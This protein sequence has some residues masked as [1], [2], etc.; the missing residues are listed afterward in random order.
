M[1]LKKFLHIAQFEYIRFAKKKNFIISL[2]SVPLFILFVFGLTLLIVSS[3]NR[4]SPIGYVDKAD[5]LKDPIPAPQRSGSP[6]DPS[7]SEMIPIIPYRSE[8]EA[9]KALDSKAIQAYYIIQEDYPETN[10]VELVYNK[11]PGGNARRQFWDFMQINSIR[12]IPREKALRVVSGSNLIIRWPRDS[13]GGFREFSEKNFFANLSPLFVTIAFFFLILMS[14]GY[15][16]NA[17]HEEKENRTMEIVITSIS[18]KEIIQGKV[19]SILLL[20][21]TQIIVWTAFIIFSVLAAKFMYGFKSVLDLLPA[22]GIVTKMILLAIPTYI[23]IASLM[24][25]VGSVATDP[26]EAHQMTMIFMLPM[27]SSFWLAGVIIKNPDGPLSLLLSFFPFSA[28]SSMS[29]RLTFYPVPYWQIAASAGILVLSCLGSIWLGARLFRFGMLRYGKK[30]N[31]KEIFS[32]KIS[33][34]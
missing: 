12:N 30:F 4:K 32:R 9:Q 24:V 33:H 17:F 10:N 14:A 27:M 11:R 20:S 8:D 6:N 31:L 23:M 34:E 13:P 28:F 25:G 22:A 21:M 29:F 7:T 18:G 15:T 3:E 26:R 2:L 16:M 19:L 1:K 5:F